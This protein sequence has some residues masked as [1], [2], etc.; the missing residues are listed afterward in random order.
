MSK[1]LIRGNATGPGLEINLERFFEKAGLG[2][3]GVATKAEEIRQ[4]SVLRF[5]RHRI[6][7][8]PRQVNFL[9]RACMIF[10][11]IFEA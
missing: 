5:G 8:P 11:V 1:R 4:G 3:R 10:F 7:L 6:E 9:L 2:C